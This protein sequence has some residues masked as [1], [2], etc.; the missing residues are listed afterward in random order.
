MEEMK[1][2]F[3]FT[4]SLPL[5]FSLVA[6]NIS[7][8]LT[9]TANLCCSSNK[10]MAPYLS[11]LLSV[12]LFAVELQWPVAYFLFFSVFLFLYIPKFVDIMTINLSLI[13]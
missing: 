5:F 8:F 6:A 3:L 13:L 10:K 11:L 7:H 2:M 4:F 9:A 12:A 1:Y